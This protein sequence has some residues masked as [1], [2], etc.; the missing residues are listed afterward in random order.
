MALSAPETEKKSKKKI[1]YDYI[2]E[3]I[4]N[5][6]L[7]P[8]EAIVERK[9]C[10]NLGVSRTS[11][12]AALADL[13]GEGLV[14]VVE[15]RSVSVAKICFSDMMEIYEMREALEC[16]SIALL[17]DRITEE[18]LEDLKQMTAQMQNKTGGEF[19]DLDMHLHLAMARYSKNKRLAQA[20]QSLYSPIR[21][22]ASTA[23]NDPGL[24]AS[25]YREHQEILKAIE[26][27]Q[28][29]DAVAA[30]RKHVRSVRE[31]HIKHYFLFTS[32]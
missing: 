11:I 17:T 16:M 12:R 1:A 22:M 3:L 4:L 8:G 6:E 25:A 20:I 14:E 28:P 26:E 32:A 27:K 2:K 5:G 29:D 13:D 10:E 24:R 7:K 31:Y 9:L 19:M 23:K 21:L 30:V 15:G 18:E